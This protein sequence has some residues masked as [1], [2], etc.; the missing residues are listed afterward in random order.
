MCI[1]AW[2]LG[3]DRCC[4]SSYHGAPIGVN[5]DRDDGGRGGQHGQEAR[6]V[7]CARQLG[8]GT[9]Q[10]PALLLVE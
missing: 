1:G 6:G 3:G 10:A 8:Q 4:G 2:L 7:H 9:L 5:G